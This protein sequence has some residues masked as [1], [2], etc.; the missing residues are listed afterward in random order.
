MTARWDWPPSAL[1]LALILLLLLLLLLPL[2]PLLLLGTM[3]PPV[4]WEM[5]WIVEV[6]MVVVLGQVLL[7]LLLL[8][9]GVRA[10]LTRPVA[11]QT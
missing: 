6:P 5:S 1:D 3:S 4:G 10:R 9:L 2:L 7:L 11:W 8:L